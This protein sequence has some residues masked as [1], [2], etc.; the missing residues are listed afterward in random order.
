VSN[1]SN[2]AVSGQFASAKRFENW[3]T[4]LAE[5]G[6]TDRKNAQAL[7]VATLQTLA[8]RIDGGDGPGLSE[9]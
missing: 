5:H 9:L 3:S 6:G 7:T 1:G 8:E 2:R 4:A